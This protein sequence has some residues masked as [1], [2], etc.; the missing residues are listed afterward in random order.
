MF[1]PGSR[2]ADVSAEERQDPLLLDRAREQ[3][4]PAAAAT[5]SRRAQQ[6]R[7]LLHL[8]AGAATERLY[9]SYPRLEVA[10]GR[11]RVPSFYALDLLRGATGRIPDHEQLEAAAAQA[12][13]S[14]LAW[15]APRDPMRAIDDQEHDLSVLR[16]CSTPMT[17]TPC[18][19]ARSTCCG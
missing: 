19:A 6:E 1:V 16:R 11:A 13:D 2:R 4:G 18:A 12:G 8:A 9:V 10:E 5:R 3:L 7:L 14:T 15:P 17:R